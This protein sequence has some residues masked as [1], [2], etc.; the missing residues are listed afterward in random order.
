MTAKESKLTYDPDADVLAW[1][2]NDLPIV[3]AKEI[4]GVVVHFSSRHVPVLVEVLEAT[5]FLGKA[6][7]ISG[8]L[9]ELGIAVPHTGSA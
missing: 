1:E 3:Y 7:D 8:I 9:Q 5:H 4:K 2:M 6:K